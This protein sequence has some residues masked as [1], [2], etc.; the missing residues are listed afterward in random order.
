MTEKL[1]IVNADDLGRT[2]GINCGI[3]EAHADGIVSSATLMVNYPAAREVGKLS[4]ENPRLGIG[5]HVALTGG[6]A[7]LPAARV[8]S[9]VDANGRLPAKPED[10][11]TR[12]PDPAEV[13]AEARAQ[14][15]RFQEIMARLPT[16]F[17]THHHSHTVPAVFEAVVMLA[18]ETARPMRSTSPQMAEQLRRRGVKTPDR[19]VDAFFGEGATEDTLERVLRDLESGAT[20]LMCHPAYVDDELRSSSGYAVAR[21]AERRALLSRR[22]RDTIESAG[23]RLVSFAEL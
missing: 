8:R 1:L 22:V 20:E 3:A 9:L 13:L 5:L 19:F 14:L 10:L 11:A 7:A 2:A 16:H 6:A 4:K 21:E 15:E 18:R 17:D 23:I 12:S